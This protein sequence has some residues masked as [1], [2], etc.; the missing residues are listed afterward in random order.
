M[1]YVINIDKDRTERWVRKECLKLSLRKVRVA[2]TYNY[3]V[4]KANVYIHI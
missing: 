1:Y 4:G 2:N 3:T